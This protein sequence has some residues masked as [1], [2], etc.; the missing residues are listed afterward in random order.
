[1]KL[2]SVAVVLFLCLTAAA[3]FA[4][5]AA[6]ARDGGPAAAPGELLVAYERGTSA[7]ARAAARAGVGGRV[8][9]EVVR[10][11]GANLHVELVRLPRGADRSA[12]QRALRGAAGVAYAEP[13]YVVTADATSNDPLFTNGSLWGM[14]GDTST[15]ANAYGSQ[16]AEAWAAGQTGSDAVHIGIIDTGIQVTHPD[17][18][19]N[20]WTNPGEIAG[21]GRDDD[22]NGYVDDIHGWDFFHRD[23][24]VYDDPIDD[25]HGTHVAGTI[26]GLGGN[27]AGVA[28]VAWNVTMISGKFLGPDGGYTSDAVKAV[29]YFVALK[30]RGINVVALNNS[31]GGGGYSST[32]AAA[33]G[34]ANS[35]GIL[36]LAAAGNKGTNNDNVPHYPSSYTNSNVV[37]V[38][39]ITSSGAKSSFSNYG[40]ASVDLGAPGSSI[41]STLPVNQYGSFSGTSMA[42][43]HVTGAVAL[44][45]AAN[46]DTTL[47]QTRSALFSSVIPTSSLSGRTVTGGRL[48]V[49]AMLGILPPGPDPE[50][51]PDPDP[52]PAPSSIVLAARGYKVKGQ[53]RVDLTWSG[54]QT[55]GVVIHRNTST[56]P[57][58]NDGS[59][60]DSLNVKGAGTYTYKVCDTATPAVCSNSVTVTF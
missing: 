12:A 38:A 54:A 53:Q 47:S 37:S 50:P 52:D 43:P 10:G 13:N 21:N 40:V 48:D 36:F 41:N 49:S 17:L 56:I 28:G 57:T 26:G 1:M 23:N 16:A 46:P 59:H 27:G 11:S 4:A 29:D 24:T 2:R 35:A 42:T 31:W 18:A 58:S 33:I 22:G 15:P 5:P 51:E 45:A 30:Q 9:E 20:V 39:S 25:D 7:A 32:L 55:T 3:L 8:A 19:G 34:R 44:Y 60:T 6:A 14:Y